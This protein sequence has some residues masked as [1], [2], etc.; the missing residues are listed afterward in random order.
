MASLANQS[1]DRRALRRIGGG[2]KRVE[3]LVFTMADEAYAVPIAHVGEILRVPPIT[4]V[5]R[6]PPYVLGVISVRGRLVTVVDLRRRL[7]L[8]E[9]Q[10]VRKTR[11]LLSDVGLT[12]SIGLI[13]DEVHQVWRLALAE[14]DPASVLGADPPAHVAGLGRPASGKGMVFVIL[15][16]RPILSAL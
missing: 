13:V 1:D 7:S 11:I 4:E 12:E 3:H 8:G 10:I 6:A 16:L 9:T 14:I 15:D 5:P 2:G